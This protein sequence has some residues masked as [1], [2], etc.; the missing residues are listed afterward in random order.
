LAPADGGR[1]DLATDV[2]YDGFRVHTEMSGVEPF[3]VAFGTILMSG[4]VGGIAPA[5]A[6]QVLQTLL[7]VGAAFQAAAR[8]GQSSPAID[9]ETVRDLLA[10]LAGSATNLSYEGVFGPT[11]VTAQD[12]SGSL[13]KLRLAFGGESNH[14]LTS[15]Y[16]ELDAQGLTLPE[17]GLG[18]LVQLIPARVSLHQSVFGISSAGLRNAIEKISRDEP[19]TPEELQALF[20]PGGITVQLDPSAIEMAGTV[21]SANGQLVATGPGVFTATAQVTATNLDQL[22]QRV[23]AHPELVQALPALIL[24]KGFGRAE[25]ARLVWDIGFQNGKLL[26]NGQ[27][28]SALLG[29]P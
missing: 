24:A 16:L 10:A 19:P 27:D 2:K 25:G 11:T 15:V 3:D 29:R 9:P 4:K 8:Q 26:V 18:E 22:Q 23:A 5:P 14:G 21:L 1:F 7:R 17:L 12:L 28:L 13:D 20:G 6:V